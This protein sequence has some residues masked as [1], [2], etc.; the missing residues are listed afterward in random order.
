[1]GRGFD[2]AK[3]AE[4]KAKMLGRIKDLEDELKVQ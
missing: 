3:V 4:F 2:P 1:M